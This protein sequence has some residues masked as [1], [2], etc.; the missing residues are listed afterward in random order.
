[1]SPR[2]A[3]GLGGGAW[4]AGKVEG[5]GCFDA[6]LGFL[7]GLLGRNCLGIAMDEY[8]CGIW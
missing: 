4:P 2:R 7:E 3:I 5:P 6:V 8:F 1:M